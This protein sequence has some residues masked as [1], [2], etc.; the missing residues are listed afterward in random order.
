[1]RWILVLFIILSGCSP[2]YEKVTK[3]DIDRGVLIELH[4][5]SRTKPLQIDF[6]LDEYAQ[7]H[8]EWMA[9]RSSLKH[10]SLQ[11][12]Y[13]TMGENIAAGQQDEK[14]V[15]KDWMK[16][17]GHRRNI[18]DVNFTHVGFGCAENS[19]G[20]PYWCTVFGGR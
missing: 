15:V 9:S 6:V 14:E 13:L 19:K 1:M 12:D 18:L 2:R 4:N 5:D 8:A 10:S 3:R 16:S 11:G 7:K 17:S 20:T